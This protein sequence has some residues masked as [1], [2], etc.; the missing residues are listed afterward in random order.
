MGKGVNEYPPVEWPSIWGPLHP[1][2]RSVALGL[3]PPLVDPSIAV[4]PAASALHVFA[5]ARA[6]RSP[7]DR[8]P[9][10]RPDEQGPA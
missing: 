4:L 9:P 8:G 5:R 6:L 1:L 2:A 10:P 3:D 7:F